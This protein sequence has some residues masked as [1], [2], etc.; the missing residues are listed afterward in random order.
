LQALGDIVRRVQFEGAAQ[1]GRRF[2]EL[3]HLE[4]APAK[5]GPRAL[6]RRGHDRELAVH[7]ERVGAEISKFGQLDRP[8]FEGHSIR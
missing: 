5:T 7:L 4:A 1:R 8:A 2:L 3:L 6:V